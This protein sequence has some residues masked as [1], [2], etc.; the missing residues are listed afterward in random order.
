M[1]VRREYLLVRIE[2]PENS[3]ASFVFKGSFMYT[4]LASSSLSSLCDMLSPSESAPPFEP[5]LTGLD[6][7]DPELLKLTSWIELLLLLPELLRDDDELLRVFSKGLKALL[8][9]L[10]FDFGSS[11][12]IEVLEVV[13]GDGTVIRSGLL[14]PMIHI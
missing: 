6:L 12:S 8:L 2:F 14:E 13:V 3:K 11:G 1:K 4:N 5:Y 10:D 7:M 9:E